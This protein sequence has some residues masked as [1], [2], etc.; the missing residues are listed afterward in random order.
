ME[1]VVFIDTGNNNF[2][3]PAENSLQILGFYGDFKDKE[4]K[5]VEKDLLELAKT[6][7]KDIRPELK[8]A[9]IKINKRAQ[10]LLLSLLNN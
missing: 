2:D 1:S 3:V 4:L 9:K 5:K 8:K 7:V 6:E 10:N